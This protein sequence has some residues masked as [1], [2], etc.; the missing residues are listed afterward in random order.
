M[1][2]ALDI[3]RYVTGYCDRKGY[4]VSNLKLQK[5]LYFIQA[6]FLVTLDIAC[7]REIIQALTFGP[8]VPQ[9]YQE[10]KKFGSSNILMDYQTEGI[11]K[12]EEDERLV[13]GIVDQCDEYSAAES[14]KF[15][16]NQSPWLNV[17]RKY[18]NNPISNQSIKEFFEN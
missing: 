10:Y 14:M 7:F 13:K 17:Y 3:A 6:E 4:Y 12:T 1:Y 16:Y 5:I 9:A 8:V 18:H 2:S 15:T 11:M